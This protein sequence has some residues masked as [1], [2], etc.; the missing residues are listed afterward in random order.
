MTRLS[1][2]INQIKDDLVIDPSVPR[3]QI[4]AECVRDRLNSQAEKYD[5]QFDLFLSGL[6]KNL[7][8]SSDLSKISK[9]LVTL[10]EI[11]GVLY[12][13]LI[14]EIQQNQKRFFK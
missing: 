14:K 6:D 2:T 9:T 12:S 7:R 4:L 5:K 10:S 13:Q 3:K 1:D 11:T 8:Y